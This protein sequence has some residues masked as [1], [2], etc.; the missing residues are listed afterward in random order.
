MQKTPTAAGD[1]EQVMRTQP[2]VQHNIT[3]DS[4]LVYSNQPFTHPGLP[5]LLERHLRTPSRRPISHFNRAAFAQLA[6]A[7][8]KAPR[9]LVLDSFCGTGHSSAQ[10]AEQFPGHWV[11]G[12]DKS[13][14]RLAKHPGSSCDNYLLLRAECEAIWRLVAE[15]GWQVDAHY[16]LYPNP[17]PK[18]TQLKRRIHGDAAF[19]YLLQLGGALEL[20]SNWQVYVEEFGL[21]VTL[22]GGN[23]CVARCNEDAAA[24]TLFERKYR[25]SGQVLW[26][27]RGQCPARP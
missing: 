27:F 23:G 5:Q 8:D 26:R 10:L 4:R 17:W 3:G 22:G 21:A 20:R 16:L 9:P 6:D 19:P 12:I 2:A 18:S 13:A 24:L 1:T 25:A 14:H 15:A 11:V 7:I